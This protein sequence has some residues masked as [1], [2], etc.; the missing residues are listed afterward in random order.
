MISPILND[1]DKIPD[2]VK[3]G[4]RILFIIEDISNSYNFFVVMLGLYINKDILTLF[5]QLCF[6]FNLQICYANC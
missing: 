1:F 3:K 5:K 6:F 4:K 2:R